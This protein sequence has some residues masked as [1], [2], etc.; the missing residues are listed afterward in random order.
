TLGQYQDPTALTTTR[1]EGRFQFGPALAHVLGSDLSAQVTVQQDLYG[2]GDQ[3]AQIGQQ[4]TLTTPLFGHVLN[5]ISYSESH[6]NGPLA[7]PFKTIDVLGNGL[8]QA[9]DV[10]RIYNGDVYSLSLTASTYFNRQ[11]QS[12]GYQLTSRPSPR[13][14]LLVGGSFLPGPGNGFDRTSVQI[15]TP[16]GRESDLQI[17]TFINWK[18]RARLES[19]NIYYR[20]IV[21]ECYEIRASYNQDLKQVNLTVSILAFPSRA[22]NFGIGQSASLGSIIPQNFA[23]SSFFGSGIPGGP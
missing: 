22:A 17:S 11:A 10:L 21:G 13:S 15:A 9:N 8:K 2:T 18:A 16:F 5:T 6:V 4:A 23:N 19:K 12:V 14:T 7:Q 1:A 3:K 20:H